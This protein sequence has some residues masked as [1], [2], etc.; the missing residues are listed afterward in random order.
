MTMTQHAGT[1]RS[2]NGHQEQPQRI[3]VGTGERM[4]SAVVGGFLTLY[5]LKRLSLPGLVVAGI[6]AAL[7]NRGVRGHCS[8]YE[9]L[10]ID[11]AREEPAR[12]EDFFQ[13]GIHVEQSVLVH[14]PAEELYRFW[15]DVENLPRFM[16][17]LEQ[18]IAHDDRRSRW[19]AKAPAGTHVEWEAEII[20]DEP[21][22]TIAWRS[23]ADAAV[24]N[25]GSVRFVPAAGDRGTEVH[26]VIDYIPPAGRVGAMV[27]K[28]FGEEP[29][30]QVRDDLRRFKQYME[31][32]E[33]PTT[34]CQSAGAGQR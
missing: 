11:T 31:T 12:P 20:N 14:K 29:S 28:L 8:L 5:G 10:N 30:Q 25:A 34:E 1:D 2:G 33:I 22:K 32:G 18:V 15:R 19:R 6:G 9:A 7:V 27:A 21:N 16:R 13:R 24:Q 26:V 4:G 3:N 17:H 23:L